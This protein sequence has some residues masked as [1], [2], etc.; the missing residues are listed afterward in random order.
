[1]ILDCS[2]S[3]PRLQLNSNGEE[4]MTNPTT[5]ANSDVPSNVN[6]LSYQEELELSGGVKHL[7]SRLPRQGIRRQPPVPAQFS[8]PDSGLSSHRRKSR[9][10][11][12]THI[13]SAPTITS[14]TETIRN[15]SDIPLEIQQHLMHTGISSSRSSVSSNHDVH[16]QLSSSSL[17]VVQQN[18]QPSM[19]LVPSG[20]RNATTT[21]ELS[22]VSEISGSMFEMFRTYDGKEEYTV[23]VREDDGKKFYVDW[24]EQVSIVLLHNKLIILAE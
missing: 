1:M 21:G 5:P 11:L 17:N 20:Q 7:A 15:S 19:E 2:Q 10:Q 4:K 12:M 18:G 6:D 23:Y 24:E 8:F 14:M 13:Q 22:A 9:T 3:T 16:T